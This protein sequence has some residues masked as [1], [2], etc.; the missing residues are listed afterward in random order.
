MTYSRISA[1]QT[2]FKIIVNSCLGYL[3][4]DEPASQVEVIFGRKW[5]PRIIFHGLIELCIA[6]NITDSSACPQNC[7]LTRRA[8]GVWRQDI[9]FL[10]I[11]VV[12]YLVICFT[13]Y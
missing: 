10:R 2:L 12:L 7:S 8:S 5:A 9:R 4:P 1:T 13:T 3:T 11:R 6:G